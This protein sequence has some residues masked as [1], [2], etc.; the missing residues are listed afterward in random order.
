MPRTEKQMLVREFTD[1]PPPHD[2]SIKGYQHV[3]VEITWP[4]EMPDLPTYGAVGEWALSRGSLAS[5][6]ETGG[7]R[8]DANQ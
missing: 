1:C 7:E 3:L 2:I 6:T 5:T 4:D 8:E